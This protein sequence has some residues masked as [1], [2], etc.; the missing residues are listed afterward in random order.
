MKGNLELETTRHMK[1]LYKSYKMPQNLQSLGCYLG[2][3]PFP[4]PESFLKPYKRLNFVNGTSKSNRIH[5]RF[6]SLPGVFRNT[7][8]LN[9]K[10]I[11]TKNSRF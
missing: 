7:T 3:L 1:K 10:K 6:N 11:S 4:M 5:L 8:N 9:F 2:A